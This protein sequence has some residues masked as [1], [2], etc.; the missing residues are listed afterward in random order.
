M[1]I[2]QYKKIDPSVLNMVAA[3]FFIQLINTSFMVILLIYMAKTGYNDARS[4]DFIS[5]RFLSVLLFSIP[6]GL[7]IRN[8]K[9]KPLFYL[10]GFSVP[11]FSIL[12]VLSIHWNKDL[13]LYINMF[14]WGLGY[15][16]LQISSL[17][18]ILRN[19]DEATR[20]EALSLNFST[21]S[22]GGIVGGLLIFTLKNT[23]PDFFDEKNILLLI[24][25]I[26][27][28]GLFFISKVKKD[29]IPETVNHKNFYHSKKDIKLLFAAITPTLILAVGAGLTI[30]FVGLFFFHVHRFDSDTFAILSSLTTAI[31]FLSV[32]AVPFFKK[33]FGHVKSIV[34]SQAIAIFLLVNLG[35]TQLYSAMLLS[36]II[37]VFCYMFR[38]PL[39]NLAQPMITDV[40]MKYVGNDNRE[41]MSA[42]QAAI[43]SGSWFISSKIFSYLRKAGLDYVYIFLITAFIYTIAVIMFYLILLKD[44]KDTAEKK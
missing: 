25:I 29:H 13:L 40:A 17:P 3:E 12:I 11:V 35:L 38:Q 6:I 28:A 24:S 30:P 20:M 34:I 2:K 31:V 32:I 27:F 39:M 18:Y 15:T 1:F 44:Y 21:W 4:A 23:V 33:K 26:S 14:F 43:W 42:L 16:C 10:S 22:F 19:T 37:A 7:Y 36:S 41:M 8:R 9:I 5:Y